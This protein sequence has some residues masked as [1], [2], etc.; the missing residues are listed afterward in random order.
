[1]EKDS[2]NWYQMLRQELCGGLA[3]SYRY[4]RGP[5]MQKEISVLGLE[6]NAST[7]CIQV[8]FVNKR[9]DNIV[10]RHIRMLQRGGSGIKKIILPQQIGTLS[11]NQG[12]LAFVGIDFGSSLTVGSSCSV[13]FDIKTGADT[14]TSEIKLP[15]N[16]IFRSSHTTSADYNEITTHLTGFQRTSFLINRKDFS[17]SDNEWFDSIPRRVLKKLSLMEL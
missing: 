6:K 16:E 5:T 11:K 4:V 10:H 8:K 12:A 7:I 3:V 17:M 13:R 9:A 15:L 1:M 14:Y 2:S